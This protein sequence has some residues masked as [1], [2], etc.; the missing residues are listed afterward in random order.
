MLTLTYLGC[1]DSETYSYLIGILTRS[2][3]CLDSGLS[4]TH[5]C[6]D[7]NV[8]QSKSGC[9]YNKGKCCGDFNLDS[10]HG[11]CG[12]ADKENVSTFFVNTCTETIKEESK[13][14]RSEGSN[15]GSGAAERDSCRQ[16][17]PLWCKVT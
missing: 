12:S 2:C 8:S 6:F 10:P 5:G 14:I 16:L 7:S 3:H 9:V 4:R 11:S 13:E 1:F 15:G 17:W